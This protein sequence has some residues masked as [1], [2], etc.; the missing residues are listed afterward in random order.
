MLPIKNDTILDKISAQVYFYFCSL[1]YLNYNLSCFYYYSVFFYPAS[2]PQCPLLRIFGIISNLR[3]NAFCFFFWKEGSFSLFKQLLTQL[4][5]SLGASP[6]P[7]GSASRRL[8]QS[9]L[10]REAEQR[11]WLLFLQK[12][13]FLQFVKTFAHSINCFR[14]S[15][16]PVKEFGFISGFQF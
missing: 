15:T 14:G 10:F 5:I 7:P 12:E 8:E 4:T 13:G 16:A 11:F 1:L 3:S 6:K 9:M 2:R